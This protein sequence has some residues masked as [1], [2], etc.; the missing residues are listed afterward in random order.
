MAEYALLSVLN[1][2][3]SSGRLSP[4]RDCQNLAVWVLSMPAN[5]AQMKFTDKYQ[6]SMTN[7]GFR[8]FGIRGEGPLQ[9]PSTGGLGSG[10]VGHSDNLNGRAQS[11]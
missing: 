4:R 5:A 8:I 1:T 3:R 9:F 2:S 10:L 6:D 11:V 7:V